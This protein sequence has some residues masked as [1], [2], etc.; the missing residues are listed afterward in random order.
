M[1]ER[2]IATDCKSVALVATK[3][4]ILLPARLENPS[5][6]KKAGIGFSGVMGANRT[7]FAGRMRRAEIKFAN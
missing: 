4:Q 3:V 6:P 7:R 5:P 2:S 1:A